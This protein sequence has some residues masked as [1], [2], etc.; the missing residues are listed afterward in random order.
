MKKHIRKQTLKNKCLLQAFGDITNYKRRLKKKV[1]S[2]KR[3]IKLECQC[4]YAT[5]MR[6]QEK[7]LQKNMSR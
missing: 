5:N 6:S 1:N 7:R 4:I 3:N 2:L